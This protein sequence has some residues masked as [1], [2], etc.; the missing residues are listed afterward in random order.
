MCVVCSAM[1]EVCTPCEVE[2]QS[3]PPPPPPPTPGR[4]EQVVAAHSE[5]APVE[6]HA[7]QLV[8]AGSLQVLEQNV[9]GEG[10][11]HFQQG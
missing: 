9:A 3:N 5:L 1:C 10:D 11:P 8:L 4:G 2:R 6:K 7:V